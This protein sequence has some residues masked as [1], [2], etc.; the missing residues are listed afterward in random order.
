MSDR[1]WTTC[2]LSDPSIWRTVMAMGANLPIAI[3]P[4]IITE[5]GRVFELGDSGVVTFIPAP[6]LVGGFYVFLACHW[7]AAIFVASRF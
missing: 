6:A 7:L 3:P 5:L 2:L 1:R 4:G